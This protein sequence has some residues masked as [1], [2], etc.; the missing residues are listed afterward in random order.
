[1]AKVKKTVRGRLRE[2]QNGG[3]LVIRCRDAYDAESKRVTA[4]Q[5]SKLEGCRY[6]CRKEGNKVIITRTNI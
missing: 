5:M 3:T 1:M 2:L 4:M 6:E